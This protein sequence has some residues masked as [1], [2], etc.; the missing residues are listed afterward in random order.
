MG[1]GYT[2]PM[3]VTRIDVPERVLQ[4]FLD[5]IEIVDECWEWR[6]AH[7]NQD[8]LNYGY[9][10]DP[11]AGKVRLAHRVAYEWWVGPLE[12]DL[13][14][15]HLCCNRSCVRPEHLEQITRHENLMKSEGITAHNA[16]KT[17]CPKNHLYDGYNSQGR[18]ICK[19]C[20]RDAVRRHRNK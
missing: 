12:D 6:G 1:L 4:N 9:F 5:K 18:R 17:H 20:Q 15:N 3:P 19:T 14:I 8:P 10:Q 2:D 13:E 11:L 16:Q 7:K